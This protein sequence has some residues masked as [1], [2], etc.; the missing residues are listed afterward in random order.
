[1]TTTKAATFTHTGQIPP[2][3]CFQAGGTVT[4]ATDAAVNFT[5]A[6][7]GSGFIATSGLFGLAAHPQPREI[8]GSS[9]ATVA[10]LRAIWRA[11]HAAAGDAACRNRIVILT[12]NQDAVRY[13]RAWQRRE[14]LRYP[15]G[16]QL[17]D[18]RASGN[19]SSLEKLSEV[20]AMDGA[21][22]DIR[23]V[24]GHRGDILN[25]AADSLAKLALRTGTRNGVS[26]PEAVQAAATIAGHR[27]ADYWGR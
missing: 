26:K 1:M 11:V 24:T 4:I 8:A 6:R 10:E 27:L 2:N 16:Y 17:R 21:R 18:A 5:R 22:Y 19:M 3:A 13:L 20:M 23:K 12:D 7:A 9:A 15:S 25:E 14:T